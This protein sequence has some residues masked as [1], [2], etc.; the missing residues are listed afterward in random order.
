MV[1]AQT[2]FNVLSGICVPYVAYKGYQLFSF[3]DYLRKESPEC[4]Q[5]NPYFWQL[6]FG[7][8]ALLIMVMVPV[9]AV[10]K[11]LFMK[12]LPPNK[13]PYGSKA[14][15]TKS[16]II[17][18]RVF[19]F[20]VYCSTTLAIFW[21]LKQ[22]NYL[23]KGLL[24]SEEYPN[25]FQNYPCQPLPRFLDDLYVIKLAYHSYETMLTLAFHRGR[26]DF[27]EFLFHHILTIALVLYSYSSNFM[28]VG[29]VVMIVM[30]FTDIFVAMFKM[31]VDVNE[32]MQNALFALMFLTWSYYRIYYYSVW[33]IY[34]FIQ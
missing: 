21:S 6:F 13:F 9:E 10:A 19:R 23:H 20:F 18:E 17:S 29:S 7:T 33:V 34:P 32:A 25:F 2:L 11:S 12:A 26:R 1:N 30:D 4:Y 31:A 8:I 16:E 3:T 5:S 15:V 27:A 22:S 28:P 24:G 14:R